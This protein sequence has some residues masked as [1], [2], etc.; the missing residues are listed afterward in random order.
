MLD[1][2]RATLAEPSMD[3]GTIQFIGSSPPVKQ[4]QQRLR[5]AAGGEKKGQDDLNGW[6]A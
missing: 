6:F 1:L 5:K 4:L 3:F 2:P